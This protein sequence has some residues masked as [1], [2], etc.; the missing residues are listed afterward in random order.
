MF[1]VGDR[2]R[3]FAPGYSDQTIGHETTVIG[4]DPDGDPILDSDEEKWTGWPAEKINFAVISDEL[5]LGPTL[6][7]Q[8]AMA[9]LT[10]M[11]ASGEATD[12]SPQ[13]V[14]R[15]AYAVADAMLIERERAK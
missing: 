1:K 7:D 12:A 9:A 15:T 14:S 8:F 2:V 13:S 3:F 11:C 5:D 10:G 6:R 4:F